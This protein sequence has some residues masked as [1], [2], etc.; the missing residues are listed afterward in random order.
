MKYFGY[1]LGFYKAK[2]DHDN[3]TDLLIYM[4]K[5]GAKNIGFA[6]ESGGVL[7]LKFQSMICLTDCRS[8]AETVA[9][10]MRT[11]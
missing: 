11:G 10:E 3:A 6:D 2:G 9:N 5:R 1:L 8:T 4:Q 7:S